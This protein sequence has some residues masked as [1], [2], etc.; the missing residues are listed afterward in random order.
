MKFL[1][2]FLCFLSFLLVLSVFKTGHAMVTGE[3][4]NCHTMHNSQNGSA[5]AKDDSGSV[6]NTPHDA[7]LIYSCLGCHTATSNTTWK[8]P[9]TKAPI[10]FNT[11]GTNYG[12]NNE[13]L[14]A[15][16]FY[17]VV[18]ADNTGHNVLS[19]NDDGTLG[20][21]VPSGGSVSITK[22]NC[23]GTEGCHG[24]RTVTS[25]ITD[26]NGA[27]HT[28]DTTIDGTTVGKSYRFLKGITG[29]EA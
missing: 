4:S 9:A 19:G 25:Q 16:N 26:L 14:S 3:C 24:N 1:K 7:L 11:V 23:A 5:V 13:G 22:I 28:I 6:T 20:N 15:G 27:H 10:V 2:T 8:D 21:K 18:S 12:Y 29:I 17:N